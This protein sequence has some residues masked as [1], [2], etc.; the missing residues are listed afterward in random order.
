MMPSRVLCT[1]LCLALQ[2]ASVPAAVAYDRRTHALLTEKAFDASPAVLRYLRDVGA[3]SSGVF[4]LSAVTPPRLLSDFVNDGT[5]RGWMAEGSIREDDY[6]TDLPM[7]GCEPPRNPPSPIDR[8]RHHFFDPDTLRGLHVGPVTLGLPAPA[9]ALGEQGR[10]SGPEDNRFSLLDARLYQLRSLIES[11]PDERE[12]QT[13]LLFRSLGQVMHILE[14][15]AQPQHTRNDMHPACENLLSGRVIHE[16]SWYEDYIEYRVRRFPF[17]GRSTGPL[18]IGGYPA[19]ALP[20]FWSYF[21]Q[22]DRQ[23]GL[24][25]FSS[26]NF[27]TSATNLGTQPPCGGREEPPCRPDAYQVF[28]VPH[29]VTTLLGIRLEAPIRLLRRTLT[30]PITQA[31]IPDV[32]V[33]TSSGA[34][35]CPCFH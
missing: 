5:A 6:H 25:D 18:Q 12:R 13:A 24:A 33:S 17:R 4:D 7:L 16:H 19:P 10:G 35:S 1:A 21:A 2:A 30:D 22:A 20:T 29:A 14:D 23:Q 26:H 9:W 32:A 11:A 3:D 31:I 8:V 27:F 15:M 28:D 34:A